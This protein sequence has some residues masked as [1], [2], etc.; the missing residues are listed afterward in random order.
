MHFL[1]HRSNL[2]LLVA[3]VWIALAQLLQAQRSNSPLTNF[4]YPDGNVNAIAEANGIVYLGGQFNYIGPYT[5]NAA[6]LDVSTGARDD[7]FPAV[8]G[9]ISVAAPDGAGGWFIGGSFASVGG[10]AHLGLAHILADNTVDPNW[11]ATVL[12]EVNALAFAG[13]SLYVGGQFY[14]LNGES[15]SLVGALDGTTGAV[16][17]WNTNTAPPGINQLRVNALAVSDNTVFVGGSFTNMGGATRTNLAALDVATGNVTAWNPSPNS[18]VN[19]LLISGNTVYVGGAFTGISG[20]NRT[21]LAALTATTGVPLN[22]ADGANNQVR[23]LALSGGTLY[24]AGFFTRI[25]GATNRIGLAALDATTGVAS[26]WNPGAYLA[27]DPS[28]ARGWAVAVSG[29]TVFAGGNFT[30]CGGQSRMRIA[31]I[32]ASTGSALAT[33]NPG[34]NNLVDTLVAAGSKLFVSGQ[35][36][37]ISGALRNNLAALDAATGAATSWNPGTDFYASVNAIVPSNGVIFVGGQFTNIGGQGRK[38]LAAISASTGN[39]TAW[40]PTLNS[41]PNSVP[42]VST[43]LLSGNTLYVGGGFNNF[44]GQFRTNLAALNATTAALTSWNPGMEGNGPVKALSL[45]SSTLYVGGTF[46]R[47]GGQVRTNLAAVE[48]VSGNALSWNPGANDV[49]NTLVA[50][51]NAV[52][53]GGRFTR[54][55]GQA[56]TNLTALDPVSGAATDW[57]PQVAFEGT[58]FP[59]E[60][61]SITVLSNS[62]IVGGSFDHIGGAYHFNLAEVDRAMGL[63]TGWDPI[64]ERPDRTLIAFPIVFT[65]VNGN[66]QLY[67]GGEFLGRFVVYPLYGAPPPPAPQLTLPMLENGFFTFRL[68]GSDGQ[69]YFIEASSD[70]DSWFSIDMVV[71]VGG[72]YD[73]TDPTPASLEN[74][75]YRAHAAP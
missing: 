72:I 64:P 41:A 55:G 36:T 44:N 46:T 53:A 47:V 61:Q 9:N 24:A 17:D 13:N 42:L 70:L 18:P 5:G 37:S 28:A 43:L 74:R 54:A 66:Q 73:Y 39:A 8:D 59:P 45:I 48:A 71:P 4:W 22:W 12:G 27:G 57:N 7:T 29:S 52:Y 35:F 30:F 11:S 38:S 51:S 10:V 69:S 19:S 63:S 68:L 3:C 21:N 34:A 50:T 58:L 65:V 16:R 6:V 2:C 40:N 26:S 31:A 56:R 14:F 1:T 25:G 32:S 62:V 33:W 15:R 67:V 20:Q 75:A 60:V 23:A 49:V